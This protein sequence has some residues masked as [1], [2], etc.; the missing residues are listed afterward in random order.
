MLLVLDTIMTYELVCVVELT[1]SPTAK[2]WIILYCII[3][4]HLT[5]KT[6]IF[7]VINNHHI[8]AL[9]VNLSSIGGLFLVNTITATS[10]TASHYLCH[11]DA[12]QHENKEIL[13]CCGI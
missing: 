4:S 6:I 11:F 5:K 10:L 2:A 13:Q 7:L 1:F 8:L 9:Q 12:P 3:K